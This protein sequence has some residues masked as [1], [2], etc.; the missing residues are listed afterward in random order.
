[1]TIVLDKA[2]QDLLFREARTPQ[3]FTDQP[4]TDEQRLGFDEVVSIAA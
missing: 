2:A 3:S 4:V 1:M